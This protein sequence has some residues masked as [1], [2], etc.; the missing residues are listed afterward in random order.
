LLTEP[1]I[2]QEEKNEFYGVLN[3]ACD[4]LVNTITDYMDISLLVSENIEV[5]KKRFAPSDLL[6]EIFVKLRQS[7]KIKHVNL[8]LELPQ[9]SDAFQINSDQAL[10]RKVFRQIIDNAVKFSPQGTV[11]IGYSVKETEIEFFVKDTGCGISEEASKYI[12]DRFIQENASTTRNYEGSGIGLSISKGLV[13]LLGGRIWFDS[14][15]DQGTSF[16]F[17]MPL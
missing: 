15:K 6:N 7:G 2:T 8:L 16:F 4:R 11:S 1:D 14:I 5:H 17:A 3:S 10:L 12:F 13:E 9:V